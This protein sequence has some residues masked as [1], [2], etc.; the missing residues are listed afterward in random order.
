MCL[1]LI[2]SVLSCALKVSLQ[3][4]SVHT[5]A[6]S[7][8]DLTRSFLLAVISP[9]LKTLKTQLFSFD[10]TFL[11]TALV[12]CSSLYQNSEGLPVLAVP[13]F[14][15][16]VFSLISCSLVCPPTLSRQQD[17]GVAASSG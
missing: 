3:Q 6:S 8:F 15:P 5:S 12:L 14:S 9:I 17:V 10:S 4:F 7:V 2:M 1:L 13:H 16:S 11:P